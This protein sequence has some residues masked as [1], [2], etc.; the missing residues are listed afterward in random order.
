MRQAEKEAAREK[1]SD[2]IYK[3]K[4]IQYKIDKAGKKIRKAEEEIIKA[5]AEQEADRR[6]YSKVQEDF[7]SFKYFV[8]NLN[9]NFLDEFHLEMFP[10]IGKVRVINISPFF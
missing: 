10:P 5:K 8:N 9:K 1:F 6:E 2:F 3:L 4:E 7:K